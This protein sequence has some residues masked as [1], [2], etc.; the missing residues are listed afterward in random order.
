MKTI[1]YLLTMLGGLYLILTV[2]NAVMSALGI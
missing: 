2:T 1:A